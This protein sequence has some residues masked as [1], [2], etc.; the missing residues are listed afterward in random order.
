MPFSSQ[1]QRA[2]CYIKFNRDKKAGRKPSWNCKE[3]EK[4]AAKCKDGSSCERKS[5][6]KRCWQHTK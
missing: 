6:S 1:K 3:W 2:A 5:K 4:C